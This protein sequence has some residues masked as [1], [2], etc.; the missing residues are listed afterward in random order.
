MRVSIAIFAV[1]AA[2]ALAGCSQGPQGPAGA[3]G[4]TGPQGPA[5]EKGDT[6]P[7]GPPGP[8]G[9]LG[10]TG[11]HAVRQLQC[12]SN[13]DLTCNPG[14]RLVSVTCP[15]GTI[16][17]SRAGTIE[18]ASCANTQGPALALCMQGQ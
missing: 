13:C 6:G 10:S 4:A 1:V 2:I 15:G 16:V 17:I 9:P 3:Q 14:E 11:L 18:S 8:P 5:G 7:G 12:G